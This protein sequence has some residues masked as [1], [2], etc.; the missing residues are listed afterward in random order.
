MQKELDVVASILGADRSAVQMH[1]GGGTPNFPHRHEMQE[2]IGAIRDRF[3]SL[4]S[5]AVTS[6]HLAKKFPLIFG[7]GQRPR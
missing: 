2:L 5:C 3:R 4:D 1:W 6:L 7:C